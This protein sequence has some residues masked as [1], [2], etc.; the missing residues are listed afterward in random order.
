MQQ[1]DLTQNNVR[2]QCY[3]AVESA[4]Q[5]SGNHVFSQADCIITDMYRMNE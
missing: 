5:N 1:A 4:A 3:Q 2:S